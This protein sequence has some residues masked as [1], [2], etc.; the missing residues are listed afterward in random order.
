MYERTLNSKTF[1][2]VIANGFSLTDLSINIL[3][4]VVSKNTKEVLFNLE[5]ENIYEFGDSEFMSI[6]SKVQGKD[7]YS[8]NIQNILNSYDD[9]IHTAN[10][11]IGC[12]DIYDISGNKV[13]D[14]S[15]GE[16]IEIGDIV[17]VDRD[18]ENNSLW[19]YHN[20]EPMYWKV[21]G[22]NFRKVGVPMLDLELQEV[23]QVV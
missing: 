14:W 5:N 21:T 4:K 3:Q 9:G 20:G 15:L 10:I 23:K 11:S 16:I 2:V 12:L 13:K 22:R 6:Q 7:I 1:A 8:H 19:K 18:N 17:R